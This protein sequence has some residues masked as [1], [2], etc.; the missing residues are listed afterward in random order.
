MRVGIFD[1]AV[2]MKY[3]NGLLLQVDQA[4][5][6]IEQLPGTG[7][8]Q[9][10]GHGIDGKVAAVQVLL[11]RTGFNLWISR[12]I[13]IKLGSSGGNINHQRRQG[14]ID[15]FMPNQRRRLETAIGL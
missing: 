9:P 3:P 15:V 1:K 6:E 2:G 7:L 10:N 11:N 5:K 8:G 14:V 12:R 13:G 4:A